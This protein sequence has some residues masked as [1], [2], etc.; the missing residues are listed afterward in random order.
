[1]HV[2]DTK[3]QMHKIVLIYV[4]TLNRRNVKSELSCV[5]FSISIYLFIY[6]FY[7]IL[8]YFIAQTVDAPDLSN[9]CIDNLVR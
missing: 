1:M 7:F 2:F 4:L 5:Y 8:F 6:S 9:T 3:V